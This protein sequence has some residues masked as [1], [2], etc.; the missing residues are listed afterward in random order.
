MKADDDAGRQLRLK[1]ARSTSDI[2]DSLEPEMQTAVVDFLDSAKKS[3]LLSPKSASA[4]GAFKTAYLAYSQFSS[5]AAHPSLTALARHWRRAEDR[6]VEIVV[7]P[8]VNQGELDQTLLFAGMA[9]LGF[10]GV[11]D[12][13]FGRVAP[14]GS[15][16]HLRD[17][18]QA[19]QEEE[20]GMLQAAAT[21][22]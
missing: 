19:L 13:M 9:V 4:A 17:E 15:L 2:F 8:D 3:D 20:G 7:R 21:D 12:E 14:D 11:V 10:L 1:F 22:T 18:L 5:D 16:V 6:I